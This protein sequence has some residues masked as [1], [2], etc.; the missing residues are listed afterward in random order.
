M[1]GRKAHPID[2]HLLDGK[3][4]NYKTKK[5]I[6]ARKKA[7]VAITGGTDKVHP[8]DWLNKRAKKEFRRLAKELIPLK[9][10]TNVDINAMARYCDAY[11]TYI[12]CTERINKEG[13]MVPYGSDGKQHP[14][15]LL[16]KK[17]LLHE[18][19]SRLEGEF[20]LTAAA[21]AKIAIPKKE[22]KEPTEFEEMFGD[23]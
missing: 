5:E 2:L 13:L 9:L 19:M 4:R 7:E 12:D 8:P 16:A 23:V 6:N 21:R 18:Q 3:N 22:K 11:I 17:K 15:P 1:M 20:G 14:H 10:I